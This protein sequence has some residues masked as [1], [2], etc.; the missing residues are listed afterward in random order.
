MQS[1]IIALAKFIMKRFLL[2]LAFILIKTVGWAQVPTTDTIP[3]YK[4]FP[5]IPSFSITT[6]P[7][8]SLFTKDSLKKNVATI[9][10]MFSPDCEHCQHETRN[11]VAKMNLFKKDV[12]I[13]MVTPLNYV[14]IE[15]FYKEYHIA[16]CPNIIMGRDPV[17]YLGGFYQVRNFPTIAVYDE[18]GKFVTLLE[19][20]VKI[21]KIVAA[22]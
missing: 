7:D 22:L 3:I 19:G 14:D 21:E 18:H 17:W 4:Q 10:I 6:V 12:Q 13:V 16:D 9:L 15:K 1:Y 20:S 5:D 8:S 11:L 2:L